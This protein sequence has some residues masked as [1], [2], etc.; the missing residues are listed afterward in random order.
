MASKATLSTLP[1]GFATL[2][3][4][5]GEIRPAAGTENTR[6]AGWAGS[7]DVQYQNT[8]YSI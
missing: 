4:V 5:T 2:K 7:V 8:L 3:P 6:D 1:D